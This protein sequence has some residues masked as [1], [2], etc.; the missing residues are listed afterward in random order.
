M[1]KFESQGDKIRTLN[2]ID[3]LTAVVRGIVS[4]FLEERVLDIVLEPLQKQ[5]NEVGTQLLTII[6]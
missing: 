2:L 3:Q 6:I 4:Y 1:V 5:S